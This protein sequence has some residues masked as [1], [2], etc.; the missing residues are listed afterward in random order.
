M[1][2]EVS[3]AGLLDILP[4]SVLLTQAQGRLSANDGHT[5]RRLAASDPL[6]LACLLLGSTRRWRCSTAAST[7]TW[8]RSSGTAPRTPRGRS[9]T[10]SSSAPSASTTS[11]V[12]LDH[13]W[14]DQAPTALW[15]ARRARASCSATSPP[16]SNS[17]AWNLMMI[18]T[19]A[20]LASS[21]PYLTIALHKQ[22][23]LEQSQTCNITC[24]GAKSDG[25]SMCIPSAS[26]YVFSSAERSIGASGWNHLYIY[27]C[28]Y[29][30]YH[31]K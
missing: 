19:T 3:Q 4:P 22:L 21:F 2:P 15:M 23:L 7:T 6:V 9:S 27:Q 11:S 20:L 17:T 25:S 18:Q 30:A 24:H 16:A 13:H 28:I 12:I 10:A 31:I 26:S 29:V 8:W 1:R 14:F 5:R